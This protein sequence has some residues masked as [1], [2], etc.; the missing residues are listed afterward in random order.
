MIEFALFIWAI[1]EALNGN[2][3]VATFI[4]LAAIWGKLPYAS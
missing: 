4:M 2:L 1:W 3:Q